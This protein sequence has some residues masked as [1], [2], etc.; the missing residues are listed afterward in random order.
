VIAPLKKLGT[1]AME[2]VGVMPYTAVQKLFDESAVP[3]RRFYLRFELPR[4]DRRP[5]D[6]DADGLLRGDAVAA[7]RDLSS[8]AWVAP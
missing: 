4:D 1:V 7:E 5:V 8:R 6:R 3:G 2:K